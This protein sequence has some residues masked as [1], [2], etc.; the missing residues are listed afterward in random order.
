MDKYVST[1]A[2]ATDVALQM[3]RHCLMHTGQ[4]RILLDQ[5]T[6]IRYRWLLHWSSDKLAPVK[7]FTLESTGSERKLN[8]TLLDLIKN[9]HAGVKQYVEDLA[10]DLELQHNCI[11]AHGQVEVQTFRSR[12]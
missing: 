10:Q 9:V 5:R 4:P 12:P 6:Q 3:W 7:H 1:D 2:E 8:L 11:A